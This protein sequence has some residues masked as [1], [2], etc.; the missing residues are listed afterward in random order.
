MGDPYEENINRREMMNKGE[1]ILAKIL[2]V[3]FNF[4]GL[5]LK[6]I[7]D[8]IKNVLRIFGVPIR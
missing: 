8:I 3:I 1:F 7:I 6:L 4:A 5:I 2:K